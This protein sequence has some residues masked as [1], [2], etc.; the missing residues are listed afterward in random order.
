MKQFTL[1]LM[2]LCTIA[3]SSCRKDVDTKCKS[4]TR[5]NVFNVIGE[6]EFHLD[7]TYTNGA[8]EA[9]NAYKREI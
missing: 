6:N 2:A 8:G 9:Y 5:V 3:I 7:S 1:L 4:Y